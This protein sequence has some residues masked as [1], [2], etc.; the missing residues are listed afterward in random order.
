MVPERLQEWHLV[1]L[2]YPVSCIVYLFPVVSIRGDTKGETL[3]RY[4]YRNT[5]LYSLCQLSF[6]SCLLLILIVMH[7]KTAHVPCCVH[8]NVDTRRKFFSDSYNKKKKK[9]VNFVRVL[10]KTV[11]ENVFS[12]IFSMISMA[13][14][15]FE[16]IYQFFTFFLE[17]S[18][19]LLR[20]KNMEITHVQYRKRKVFCKNWDYYCYVSE[21]LTYLYDKVSSGKT[22]LRRW[23]KTP[24]SYIRESCSIR[25]EFLRE[26]LYNNI[27]IIAIQHSK[28]HFVDNVAKF[29]ISVWRLSRYW[30][31]KF[32]IVYS[33]NYKTVW[34]SIVWEL[35]PYSV[36]RILPHA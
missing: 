1:F 18:Q 27:A 22:N 12:I 31:V 24:P 2:F 33:T 16:D 23:I 7:R 6:D 20:L 28:V 11:S 13:V 9:T 3:Y 35:L 15:L 30:V 14:T 34:K 17:E 36:C 8:N 10:T 19:R 25:R 4:I 21:A 26:I 5:I 29:A 32:T